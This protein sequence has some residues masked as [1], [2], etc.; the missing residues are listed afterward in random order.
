MT[1][2]P[3]SSTYRTTTAV[4]PRARVTQQQSGARRR[5]ETLSVGLYN[6]ARTDVGTWTWPEAL[7]KPHLI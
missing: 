7:R 3:L 4:F 2:P 5:D 1:D 6:F